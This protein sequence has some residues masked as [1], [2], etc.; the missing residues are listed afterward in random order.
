[1]RKD[2]TQRILNVETKGREILDSSEV[3]CL[4]AKW[5][6]DALS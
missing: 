5:I 3:S 6:D 4:G 2:R 1:M